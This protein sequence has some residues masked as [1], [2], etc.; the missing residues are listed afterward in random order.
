MK[1]TEETRKNLKKI[2]AALSAVTAYIKSGEEM[3]VMQHSQAPAA[4]DAAPPTP[5]VMPS[6]WGIS[7]RQ[8]IM[9]MRSMMQM[10]AFHGAR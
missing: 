7:G 9:Q 5:A 10:K 1:E 2:A 8:D 3:A 4:I 6:L